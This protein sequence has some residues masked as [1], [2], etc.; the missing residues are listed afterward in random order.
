MQSF[1]FQRL[2]KAIAL[3]VERFVTVGETIGEEACLV[4]GLKDGSGR[5]TVH[6]QGVSVDQSGLSIHIT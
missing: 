3:S 1:I 2:G 5:Q 6:V 4:R